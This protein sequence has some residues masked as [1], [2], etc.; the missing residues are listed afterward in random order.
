MSF[1]HWM[2]VKVFT[3]IT[4]AICRVHT[5]ELAKVPLQGPLILL[6]NHV[7]VLEIP[8]LYTRLQPRPVTG[9]VAH[10]RWDNAF[11]RWL[12]ELTG[13]IPVHRGEGDVAM[14]KKALAALEAGRMLLLAPEGTRSYDGRL[15]QGSP[16]AA[17]LAL[18]SGAPVMPVVFWGAEYY[19]QKMKRL[20]RADFFI[21]VGEPFRLDHHGA[22]MNKHI[23]QQMVDEIMYEMAR[24]LPPEYRGAYHDLSLATRQWIVGLE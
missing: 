13:T 3:G 18:K 24:L 20:K 14:M 1:Q 10:I 4:A 5:E 16:G 2:A 11:L 9:M 22:R 21:R 19:Q 15:Q 17:M 7:N 12:L 8:V 6:M 23:R